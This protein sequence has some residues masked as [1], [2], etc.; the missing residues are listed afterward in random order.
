MITKE[1]KI[2][3]KSYDY[4]VYEVKHNNKIVYIGSGKSG[5]EKH[6]L[7]GKSSCVELNRIF[8]T[9]PDSLSVTVIREGLSKEES[10]EME[11]GYILASKPIY[12]K[13]LVNRRSL[14]AACNQ[15]L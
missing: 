1:Y 5:R 2:K 8:F 14:K 15:N 7:S 9:D 11:K 10:L 6:P 4:I 13:Q 12:N 3:E